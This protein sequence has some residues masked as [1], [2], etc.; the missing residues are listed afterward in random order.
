LQEQ[1]AFPQLVHLLFLHTHLAF[2]HF[3]HIIF[4]LF[5]L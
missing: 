2:L 3:L 4:Y 5:S 1:F